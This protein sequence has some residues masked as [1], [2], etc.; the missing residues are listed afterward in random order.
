MKRLC[1]IS[2]SAAVLLVCFLMLPSFA[3]AGV[4][5]PFKCEMC[6]RTL[7]LGTVVHKPVAAKACL[8]CH[9]QFSNDHPLGKGSVGFIVPKEKLCAVCHGQLV[10]KKFLHGPVGKGNC[11]ACHLPHNG[12]FA[13][14]LKAPPPKLCFGCHPESHFTGAFGHPPVAKGECLSCHD[15]HQADVRMLLRKPGEQLCFSCHDAKLAVGKSVHPPVAKGECLGCH[16]PHASA[17]R[18]ILKGD[19]TEAPYRPFTGADSFPLCF[20]CHKSELASEVQTETATNFRNGT[21]NLHAVHVNKTSKGRS[22]KICHNPHAAGQERLINERSPSFGTWTIPI[23]FN[24]T[25]TG[26]GCS[27]GC[28][29]TYRYDRQ[30]AVVQ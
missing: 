24:I 22:C 11:T 18:K 26:G 25:Q 4:A 20:M 23:Y 1:T 30:K 7:H 12:E 15:A 3:L 8:K 6:H 29:R 28:H 5:D 13:K 27:V 21:R 17:Y 19:L 14:L 9:E 10:K 16:Q 2:S